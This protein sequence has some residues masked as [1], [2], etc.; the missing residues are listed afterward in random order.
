MKEVA[1]KAAE[2]LA[3]GVL[4][5]ALS[6]SRLEVLQ[7]SQPHEMTDLIATKLDAFVSKNKGA[8]E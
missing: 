8:A 4:M 1:E 7:N 3:L 2:Q 6:I 5:G